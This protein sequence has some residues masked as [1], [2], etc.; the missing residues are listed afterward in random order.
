MSGPPPPPPPAPASPEPLKELHPGYDPVPVS[1]AVY[2]CQ[3]TVTLCGPTGQIQVMAAI[4]H[5]MTD[6]EP[7]WRWERDGQQH[8][9]SGVHVRRHFSGE[10]FIA[11]FSDA[12]TLLTNNKRQDFPL[13]LFSR[14]QLHK[15]I[16]TLP[17]QTCARSGGTA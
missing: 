4:V 12:Q 6:G 3:N 11:A 2:E 15:T 17:C 16:R 9:V 13:L 1:K 5:F 10:C 8:Q 14:A 7:V